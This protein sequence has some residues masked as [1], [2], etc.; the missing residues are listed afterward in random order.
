[1]EWPEVQRGVGRVCRFGV[2]VPAPACVGAGLC[3]R[4]SGF[5][6]AKTNPLGELLA[7]DLE[8]RVPPV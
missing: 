5:V 7:R 4:A 2:V 3:M 1:M 6:S 8:A